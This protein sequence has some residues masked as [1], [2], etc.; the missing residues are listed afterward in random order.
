MELKKQTK[1]MSKRFTATEKWQDPWFCRLSERDRLFWLFLLDSC[2]HAGIWQVNEL[3]VQA[4]FP[5][6]LLDPSKFADRIRIITPEKWFIRKFISFQYGE[7]NP[8][9]RPHAS[10]LERLRKEGVSKGLAKGMH[11]LMDKDKAKEKDKAKDKAVPPPFRFQDIWAR[12][13]RQ[14]GRKEAERCFNAT[15]KTLEAWQKINRALDNYLLQIRTD[16]TE[17][18]FIKM[19]S[20]WFN[21]WQDEIYQGV[22]NAPHGGTSI[23]EQ[24]AKRFRASGPETGGT[25]EL[26]P[27]AVLARVRNLPKVQPETGT[28]S[29]CGNDED[30]NPLDAICDDDAQ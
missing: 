29:G 16:A 10:V 4:Y 26:S 7:L 5:G 23:S 15:V 11:T 30:G 3:V 2:D 24:I 28:L 25:Q 20:T 9:S 6:Y 21:N 12:Y 8:D 27:R 13:P 18:K 17:P 22:P 1:R 14:D 19:G